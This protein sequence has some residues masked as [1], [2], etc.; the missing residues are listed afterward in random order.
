M[1]ESRLRPAGLAAAAAFFVILLSIPGEGRQPA[2]QEAPPLS[3]DGCT[4]VMVGR[5]ASTD[6]STMTTHAAD[7]LRCD[8]TW[9]HVPAA[10][11][12]PGEMRR[13][14]RISPHA[15]RPPTEE[16]YA[17]LDI[18]QVPRTFAYH[19]GV[20]GY[21]NEHQLAIAESTIDTRPR[22]RNETPG[23]AFTMV[24]LTM[25]AMERCRTAREAIAL[26]GSLAEKYG[27][28]CYDTGEMLALAD[29]REVWVFEIMPVGPLWTPRSGRPGAV[30]CAQRVPDGHVSVCANE[31][32]I[33]EIDLDD[34]EHFLAS[35][36][37]V[38][39]AVENS[40]YDPSSGRPFNWKK[41]YSPVERSAASSGGGSS[42]L[43]RFYNLVAPSLKIDP[44]TPNMDLP[45]SV[46]PARKLSPRD[47][48]DITRDRSQ[49]SP[50]D[51]VKGIQGG[52]FRNPNYL[53]YGFE[54]DGKAY[55]TTRSI[56]VNRSEYTTL[57]QCRSWLPGPIGG[58][59]WLAF[60]ALDTSCYMPF[61][62]GVTELP[63]SFGIGDHWQ[64][65]RKSA[66]WAFDYVDFHV[67]VA[68]AFAIED[69]KACQQKWETAALDEMPEIEQTAQELYRKDP[70]QAAAYLTDYC[71]STAGRVVEAWWDLGD[72][73]LVKYNHL[74]VYDTEKKKA[75]SVKY[76]ESWIKA[77]IEI[78]KPA[79]LKKQDH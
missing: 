74:H 29:P 77:V 45:F 51:P 12:R 63:E 23:P 18:P 59:V 19:Q 9:T 17:G 73:L 47:V 64:F 49:G 40:Y 16:Q 36:N 25:L 31:S 5:D 30:W 54:A 3:P 72:R 28:G 32:R 52:P 27:F 61:Y 37:V 60:G 21:L 58:L 24:M 10:D 13:I 34:R 76:P 66:R 11:H 75:E 44:A 50:F 70:G 1:R 56:S 78:D 14:Y 67:Q 57:T 62:A 46:K 41:A 43:W 42:R 7:C 79:P 55:G 4:V 53:P 68:Y 15:K 20:Y 26:M 71:V 6:G 22:M 38:S 2:G 33:G 65:D 35:P 69:V 39:Y 48:M 8:F